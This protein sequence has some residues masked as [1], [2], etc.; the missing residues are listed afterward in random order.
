ME[1]GPEEGRGIASYEKILKFK[2]EDLEDK[3]V[4]DLG[5]G[6]KAR[7]ARDLE[8]SG[9]HAT[10]ISLSPE[11]ADG[12][13]HAL[14]KGEQ[15]KRRLEVAGIG[16]RL[17]FQDESF[18]EV[19]ALYSVS[20]WSAENYKKWLPE[21]CRVLKPAGTARIGTFNIHT[22][23]AH[24]IGED[25]L[26]STQEEQREWIEDFIHGLGY[27][28]EFVRGPGTRQDILIIHKTAVRHT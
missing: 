18:D 9:V 5:A 16:E 17:P 13:Q 4:L 1:Q 10:V 19:L 15:D 25:T 7:F 2:K 21:I 24:R 8:E 14:F 3:V 11:Y 28:Y 20:I 23:G 26:G 6:P 12:E 22:G 27:E